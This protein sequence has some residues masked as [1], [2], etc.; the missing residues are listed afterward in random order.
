MEWMFGIKEGFDV[1]IGNPPYVR[2]EKIS[3]NDVSY[4]KNKYLSSTGK[5]DLS[6]IFIEKAINLGSK[7]FIINFISTYQFLYTSSSIGLRKFII[8]NAD[9]TVIMFSSDNQ[10]FES[11]TTYTG[12]FTFKPSKLRNVIVKTAN[13]KENHVLL[14]SEFILDENNFKSDKVIISEKNLFDKFSNS[15]STIRGIHIGKAKCGVVTSCDEVFFINRKQI[16]DLNLEEEIIYP[17]LGSEN[18]NKYYLSIPETYCIYPYQ[19]IND[20]TELIPLNILEYK[21]PNIYRYLKSNENILKRRSQGR[22]TY[23]NSNKWYQLNRPREKWI[24]DSKKIIASGTTNLSKFAI[25]NAKSVFRNARLYSLILNNENDIY[26]KLILGVLNSK[27]CR[28][29]LNLK[30]PPKSGGYFELSTNFLEEFP[31]LKLDIDNNLQNKLIIAVDQIIEK[32]KLGEDTQEL[33]DKID[34]MVYKLYDLNYEEVKIVDP[35]FK[36]SEEEYELY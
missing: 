30:C 12:I 21:Y 23:E 2:V 22:K 13:F 17:I 26:Y 9:T 28:Y 24:Y 5:F 29:L 16:N 6:S 3:K 36:L 18:L 19:F 15:K 4:F 25:D 35:E 11:A 34:I 14:E 33:E 27:I 1:V 31:Y 10:I 20:K 8:D 7:K 32:K